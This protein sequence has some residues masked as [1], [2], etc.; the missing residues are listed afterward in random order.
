[1]FGVLAQRM[2]LMLDFSGGTSTEVLASDLREALG[3][4]TIKAIVLDFDSP[5]GTV[6]GTDELATE[7][8]NSRGVK[9]IV[10]VVNSMAAS[11][12]HWLAAQADEIVVTPSG[13]A[14]SIGIYTV[15]EDISKMLA[16]QGV[17]TT[18]ISAGKYKTEA[19][20]YGPLSEEAQAAIQARVD[21]SYTAFVT[22]VARGRGVSR[23]TVHANYGQGRMFGT[24][25]LVQRGMAD[26]IGTLP[27][28][29][30]RHGA[31]IHPAASSASARRQMAEIRQGVDALSEIT[32]SMKVR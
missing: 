27:Q 20:P 25:E 8:Y 17:N 19:N 2:N 24:Q 11:A 12:A 31:S 4:P 5:G 3:D 30:E 7:I 10:A 16:D 18:L 1:M 13:Q 15:H 21:Q 29:L 14:G 26:R 9:P 6:A 32:K 22:A 28:V 23:S